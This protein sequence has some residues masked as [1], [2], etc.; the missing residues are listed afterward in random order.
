MRHLLFVVY[1]FPPIN[2][3][4]VHR[5]TGFLKHLDPDEW[6]ISILTVAMSRESNAL[7]PEYPYAVPGNITVY[8]AGVIDLFKPWRYLK[9]LF[10]SDIS[11]RLSTVSAEQEPSRS[12][13]MWRKIKDK[14][15]ALLQ[16]PDNQIGWL[17]PA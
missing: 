1:Y 3:S 5:T 7:N 11:Q 10:K 13:S 6:S 12:N 9:S 16:T 14:V 2:S 15:S 8:R 4:G 17:L